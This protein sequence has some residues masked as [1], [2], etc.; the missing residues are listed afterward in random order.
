LCHTS[1]E[2][3]MIP[4]KTSSDHISVVALPAYVRLQH[5]FFALCI[6]LA[7]ITFSLYVISWNDVSGG[8]IATSARMGVV[9][10]QLHFI[11]GFAASFF[12]PFGYL[13]MALLGIR[14]SP[15][16]GSISAFLGLLCWLP[17]SALIGIDDLA[18]DITLRGSNAQLAA[19][20]T[21]F[22]GDA[23]MSGYLWV[24]AAG[25]LI[26]TVLL[27]VLL[28]RARLI[29]IWAACALI[30]SSPLTIVAFVHGQ[31]YRSIISPII[32]MLLILGCL[33][34]AIAMLKSQD[35]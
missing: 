21:Y 18:Y 14:R 7:P 9:L 12:L 5:L 32:C 1:K 27:G 6:I 20:W 31:Q 8:L 10:N 24:Y 13:G 33:P 11:S 3:V 4:L 15:W 19:L 28:G 2:I 16:L 25:H 23:M 17:L 22:N 30:V 34:A 29:P 26:S 35:L